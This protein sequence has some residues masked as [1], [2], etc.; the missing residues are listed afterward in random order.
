M[1]RNQRPVAQPNIVIEHCPI[2]FR[3]FRAPGVPSCFCN[4]SSEAELEV[5]QMPRTL[6][7]EPPSRPKAPDQPDK[8]VQ[9]ETTPTADTTPVADVPP[10]ADTAPDESDVCKRSKAAE[11]PKPLNVPIS[12]SVLDISAHSRAPRTPEV[13]WSSYSLSDQIEDED[14]RRFKKSLPMM[15][16]V[17][18]FVIIGVVIMFPN[19]KA[20]PQPRPDSVRAESATGSIVVTKAGEAEP[21]PNSIDMAVETAVVVP[22]KPRPH[23]PAFHASGNEGPR[24]KM[25][26]QS[27]GTHAGNHFDIAGD[28]AASW[29]NAPGRKTSEIRVEKRT[30]PSRREDHD[31]ES[32]RKTKVSE[33]VLTTSSPARRQT[34]T[35]WRTAKEPPV[36]GGYEITV[37]GADPERSIHPRRQP[38]MPKAVMQWLA[39]QPDV[40]IT[41]LVRVD[42]MGRAT[43]ERWDSSKPMSSFITA[44]LRDAVLRTGWRPAK[45]RSGQPIDARVRVV[46]EFGGRRR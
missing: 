26:K 1:S 7:P 19:R 31:L 21:V 44:R 45:D 38:V 22:S 3:P 46:F 32:P 13:G 17:A 37:E 14:F 27:S 40:V 20:Q 39:N 43:I 8:T 35:G 11:T 30:V 4:A 12:P 34:M 29:A 10:C 24:K 41:A 16:V 18:L 28:L 2:C 6:D 15:L 33:T 9:P 42:R 23:L 5:V 25:P 36:A